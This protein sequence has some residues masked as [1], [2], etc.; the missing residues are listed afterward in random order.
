[1]PSNA[2]KISQLIETLTERMVMHGDIDCVLPSLE[3]NAV[4]AIDGRNVNVAGEMLGQTLPRPVLVIGLWR[5]EH[6]RLRNMPGAQYAASDDDGYWSY[7][8]E[9]ALEDTDLVVWKR[10]GG[11]DIG[12]RVGDK[13]YVREG[14]AE[15]PARPVE[16]IPAGILAWRLP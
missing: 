12:K 13:W 15:W 2:L 14:A 3:S 6:G 7:R 1:M 5:D 9:D 11:Q 4:I 16:I 8:R 10:Y